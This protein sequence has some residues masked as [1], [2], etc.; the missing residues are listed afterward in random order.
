[1]ALDLTADCS[2]CAA[3]CCMALPFDAGESFAID[4]PGGMGC[5]HLARG[6]GCAIHADKGAR[7]FPGC[8]RYTC[9]GAGPY[10][11]E[12]MFGGQSWQD[13]PALAAPMA[14]AFA[15]M[16]RIHE[17]ALLLDQAARLPLPPEAA[18][19]RARLAAQLAPEPGWRPESARAFLAGDG[20]GAIRRFLQSL[21]PYVARPVSEG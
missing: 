2:R 14:A 19:E 1:M 15:D 18:A 3:L 12:R 11:T 6:G 4:K 17:L 16:A 5:P 20:P 7:G 13:S 21:A 10:V 8:N 9:H